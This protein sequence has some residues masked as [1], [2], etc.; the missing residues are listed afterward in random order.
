MTT[1]L[2]KRAMLVIL[3]FIFIVQADAMSA[4]RIVLPR[5]KPC[6]LFE[7]GQPIRLNANLE[8]FESGAGQVTAKAVDYFGN[9]VWHKEIAFIAVPG[10]ATTVTLDIGD[11]SPGYYALELRVD[12]P[13]GKVSQTASF[14][15]APFIH[16]TAKQVRDGGYRF[17][18]KKWNFKSWSTEDAVAACCNLGLQWTR[19][20]FNQRGDLG[21]IDMVNKYPMNAVMK[22]E[23]FPKELY[24]EARYGPMKDWEAKY[25][26]GAWTLKTLPMK[27]PYQKWLRDEIEKIPA[28]QNVFEIWNEAWD[29]M[30]PE[31]FAQICNW[32]SEVILTA[33]PNAI[34][35]PNF[36]GSISPYEFDARVIK[37]GGMKG[38]KMVA[39]HPYGTSEDRAWLR[40]Y[41]KWVEEQV[42]HPVEIHVTEFGSHSTPEGPAKRSEREQAQRVVRQ[43]LALYAEDVKTL[44]PHWMG[45]SEANP[46]YIE[47]WFGFFR[48]N[49][50]PKPVLMAYA[51]AARMIDGS[52][53]VGDL[54]LG[55]GSDAMLFERN[56]VYTLALGTRG[57]PAHVE[58]D[59]GVPDVTVVD[60]VGAEKK[61]PVTDGNVRLDL[62]P[63][64]IYLVGVN[65]SLEK[66]ASKELR[67]D[68]WPAPAKPPRIT[69]T[70]HKLTGTFVADGKLD[71][72]KGA[73]QLAMLNPKVNGDDASGMSY[74]AWDATYLYLAVEMRD[75]EML[76]NKPRAKLYLNDSV[77]FLVSTEPR[78]QNPGY[79]PHDHQFFITPTSGEGKPIAAEVTDRE[80][81][82]L[83][84]LKDA[85][86]FGSKAAKGWVVEIAIPW[87]TLGGFTPQVG[88]TLA[89]EIRVNDADTSHERFKIDPSDVSGFRPENPISWS[90]MLLER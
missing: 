31:D 74:L 30:S 25:G 26:R 52:R 23:R 76:N 4:P 84:D 2:T 36:L 5:S 71:E 8:G 65:P 48:L 61:Q 73:T 39:L 35:G 29:K 89:M 14:G 79:G 46:T 80:A 58:I 10:K 62:G 85:N 12:A 44:S 21:L 37:A 54:W 81:G 33:R 28:E 90:L 45:Q 83:T 86:F 24:D 87:K 72:W 15:S 27:A 50:Q 43:A 42:G 49:Q 59:P 13:S 9:D 3:L 19:E 77:E 41:R 67:P 88:A 56:G 70:M 55:T 64:W 51:N 7:S 17:G 38:M 69:R 82:T 34:I 18:L 53:Y 22:V 68:R 60:M 66:Q 20:M 75:N 63:D 6:N 40:A 32:A 16:R 47:D 1:K 57:E 78:E 11:V